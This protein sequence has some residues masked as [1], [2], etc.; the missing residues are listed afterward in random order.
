MDKRHPSDPAV[1]KALL[2]SSAA[3]DA[4]DALNDYQT[5]SRIAVLAPNSPL[6]LSQLA[7]NTAFALSEIPR[8]GRAQAV[9]IA[10]RATDR[11]VELAP[12]YTSGG[13]PWCLLHSEVRKIECEERLRASMRANTDDPFSNFFLASLVLN[14]VG[15]N[16]EAADLSKLSLAHDQYMPFKIGL[17]LRTLEA[18]DRVTEAADLYRQAR[19]WWPE[20]PVLIWFRETGMVQR[21]DFAAVEKFAAELGGP[22]QAFPALVAI[23]RKSL[24]AMRAACSN[25]KD[26]EGIM[27]MLA[28]ARDGDANAAFALADRLYPSRSGRGPKDEEQIWLD[29]PEAMPVTFLAGAGAAPLRKDPRYLPLAQRVGLLAY[30]RSGRL[31]DFCHQAVPEPMCSQLRAR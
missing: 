9:V 30:W 3:G 7:F 17:R 20:N 25:A 21:G 26:L 24:P 28:L 10:R 13:I 11:T 15:R 19:R 4:G 23:N 29:N 8:D 2:Q 12:E 5:A 22:D 31:P 6:A 18:T 14:P 1:F 27:C 16:R